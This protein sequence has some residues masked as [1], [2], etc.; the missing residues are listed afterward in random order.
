M[1]KAILSLV[2]L[3]LLTFSISLPLRADSVLT[4]VTVGS[5]PVAVA[6]N[7]ATNKIYV[8]VD[9]L[10][11]IAVIDGKT[12][13]VTAT[14]NV[15]RNVV[16][17]AVNVLTN[18]IYASGCNSSACNIWVIDGKTDT[19]ITKIPIASGNFLGIQGLA[20]NSVTNRVYPHDADHQQYIVIDCKTNTI[21]TQVPIFTQPAGVAVNP[22]TNRIYIAGGGFPGLILVFDGDTNAQLARIQE[23]SS[24][25]GLAANFR[26]DRAYG[27][28][29]SGV[30][31]VVNGAN[32]QQLTEVPTGQ[33]P[34][35]VDVN[36]RNNKVYV[37][38][39]RGGSVTIID[40]NTNQ[41]LQTLPIP[42]GFP[43][44][45]GVNVATGLTYVSDFQSDKVLVLQPN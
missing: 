21:I 25:I 27:T 30:L 43:D 4:T 28:V 20:A 1:K 24:V 2:N 16:A 37:A 35:G 22:K 15:G 19:I 38:N 18:R 8:S 32:N 40:G 10:G 6:A 5:E 39:A 34:A 42:A 13:Q 12:Q 31:A 11:Q 23:S 9:A 3:V 14:I 17:V 33:F 26:L 29:D 44:G 7:P 45:V 36:L 41:V